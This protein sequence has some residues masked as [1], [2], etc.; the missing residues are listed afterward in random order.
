METAAES[1]RNPTKYNSVIYDTKLSGAA[2][3]RSHIRIVNFRDTH[4]KTG[5]RG[6]LTGAGDGDRIPPNVLF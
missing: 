6:I 2:S 3:A 5:V 1:K 4:C